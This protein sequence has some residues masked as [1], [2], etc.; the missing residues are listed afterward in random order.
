MPE[1]MGQRPN[2]QGHTQG[3]NDQSEEIRSH[4]YAYQDNGIPETQENTPLNTR[5]QGQ[6]RSRGSKRSRREQDQHEE[7]EDVFRTQ[8]QGQGQGPKRQ[9]NEVPPPSPEVQMEPE[10][11][12]VEGEEVPQFDA[13]SEVPSPLTHLMELMIDREIRLCERPP[14]TMERNDGRDGSFY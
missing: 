13:F 14:G 10:E 12:Q 8:G 7:Q 5:N 6:V 4:D 9:K 11:Q 1:Y 3:Q 2:N